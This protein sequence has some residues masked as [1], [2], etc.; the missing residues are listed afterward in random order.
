MFE[1]DRDTKNKVR[2]S[3]VAPVGEGKER[4]GTPVPKDK[5]VVEK[6]YVSKAWLKKHGNPDLLHVTIQAP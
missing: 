2:F 3:E 6:L 1:L 5:A 4:G